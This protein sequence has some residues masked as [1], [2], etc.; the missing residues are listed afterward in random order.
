MF[1]VGA[2]SFAAAGLG[3]ALAAHTTAN[4]AFGLLPSLIV[5]GVA[6]ALFQPALFATADAAPS[7]DLSSASALLTMARQ[8]GSAVGLALL[9]AVLENQ[10]APGLGL[11]RRAW[12]VVIITAAIVAA[13][14]MRATTVSR[15]A[16][17]IAQGSLSDATS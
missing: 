17:R 14:G 2:A 5:W 3:P 10:H 16:R 6:N 15:P 12:V 9:V 11:L 4:Y 13:A 8:L 1:A 7:D